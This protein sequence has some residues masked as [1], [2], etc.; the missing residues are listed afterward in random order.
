MHNDSGAG[1]PLTNG[2]QRTPVKHQTT[3]E[4][5]ES[6]GGNQSTTLTVVN[7]ICEVNTDNS[8]NGSD[9]LHSLNNRKNLNVVNGVVKVENFNELSSRR[10]LTGLNGN[11]TF[12]RA[13]P[14][15]AVNSTPEYNESA[16]MSRKDCR[17]LMPI[18]SHQK[19]RTKLIHLVEAGLLEEDAEVIFK[20]CHGT[21]TNQG[22]IIP[23]YL[24]AGEE[25]IDASSIKW[26]S[27]EYDSPSAFA[28][29]VS[30][31]G[32]PDKKVSA[33]GWSSIKILSPTRDSWVPL[34]HYRQMYELK[35]ENGYDPSQEKFYVNDSSIKMSNLS[36]IVSRSGTRKIISHS[37]GFK[38]YRRNPALNTKIYSKSE[39]SRRNLRKLSFDSQMDQKQNTDAIG[40]SE[41]TLKS[42]RYHNQFLK[43]IGRDSFRMGMPLYVKSSTKSGWDIDEG[44]D[45]SRSLLQPIKRS[46]S[47]TLASLENIL[48]LIKKQMLIS[49]ED[50]PVLPFVLHQTIPVILAKESSLLNSDICFACGTIAKSDQMESEKMIYCGQCGEAYHS[51]CVLK[52]ENNG[53][54]PKTSVCT[55]F[56]EC[57]KCTV[58][59]RC[60]KSIAEYSEGSKSLPDQPNTILRCSQCCVTV[61]LVCQ[62]KMDPYVEESM[63]AADGQWVCEKCV[64]CVECDSNPAMHAAKIAAIDKILNVD[65]HYM[66]ECDF[67]ESESKSKLLKG[68]WTHGYRLCSFC[69]NLKE[70]G[71]ICPICRKLYG[72]DDYD[73]PM[74]QCDTCHEWIHQ[75]CDEN[76]TKEMYDAM[77]EDES[78][79][80]YCP[81]CLAEAN[82]QSHIME[83]N[84]FEF[85]IHQDLT[86][87][88]SNILSKAYNTSEQSISDDEMKDAFPNSD[89]AE[90]EA[91][92]AL[93][94]MFQNPCSR[95]AVT[96]KFDDSEIPLIDD[97][98][99]QPSDDDPMMIDSSL[100]VFSNTQES[101]VLNPIK[102]PDI[103]TDSIFDEL[104][105]ERLVL[106][107]SHYH[108]TLKIDS[109]VQSL[110]ESKKIPSQMNC[111]LCHMGDELQQS[112]TPGRLIPFWISKEQKWAHTLCLIFSKGVKLDVTNGG[113][114]G[115][116]EVIKESAAKK[117]AKCKNT[118]ASLKCEASWPGSLKSCV[119]QYWHYP[120]IASSPKSFGYRLETQKLI[121]LC[122][123]HHAKTSQELPQKEISP[124]FNLRRVYVNPEDS[125]DSMKIWSKPTEYSW[126]F[127]EVI[128]YGALIIHCLGEFSEDGDSM[129]DHSVDYPIPI[130]FR[131]DRLYVQSSSGRKFKISCQLIAIDGTF[132]SLQ[133]RKRK[134]NEGL[135]DEN[136]VIIK[137]DCPNS[138]RYGWKV[139]V[140]EEI[141]D[142]SEINRKYELVEY[143]EKSSLQDVIS[144][145]VERFLIREENMGESNAQTKNHF[146]NFRPDTFFGL[147]YPL[148][149]KLIKSLPNYE[150]SFQAMRKLQES[151]ENMK[152]IIESDD[153]TS[154][155][156]EHSSKQTVRQIRRIGSCCHITILEKENADYDVI[157]E[158]Q[159]L[160]SNPHGRCES[161]MND[162]SLIQQ[163]TRMKEKQCVS[164]RPTWGNKETDK[165]ANDYV[166]RSTRRRGSSGV[167]IISD[168]LIAP[169]RAT[170]SK[171]KCPKIPPTDIG[172]FATRAFEKDEMIM[173]YTG[174]V[175]SS[176]VARRLES[177]YARKQSQNRYMMWG[178]INWV[179]DASRVGGCARYIREDRQHANTYA[180]PFTIN[181]KRKIALFALRN[182]KCNEEITFH[183]GI[184]K[185]VSHIYYA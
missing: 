119:T 112:V 38:T 109:V 60:F 134:Y 179:I 130:G 113:L 104:G 101:V 167:L 150:L 94:S 62:D 84:G 158:H 146:Y 128:R 138:I 144:W 97:S 121:L 137:Y 181:S 173:E 70:K 79:T 65:D 117:C 151:R 111:V 129:V 51:F 145:L 64:S 176:A 178:D 71:N 177:K 61:H 47:I 53:I 102:E 67:D 81:V 110:C 85:Q 165:S 42:R 76:M 106:S 140:Q 48:P 171:S 39:I 122:D 88:K 124:N 164:L 52:K 133:T 4:E 73:I 89:S 135:F 75:E 91:A 148:I 185:D 174:V 83:E 136:K 153:Y 33:N 2:R 98:K 157:S 159:E 142:V 131:F 1:R 31:A 105:V 28:A 54:S 34:D 123:A 27:Q 12:A 95:Q 50:F 108:T 96:F 161:I 29:A 26:L 163:Y 126:R 24:L 77:D 155:R 180:K 154:A 40:K 168:N 68:P 82:D 90:R 125:S 44:F 139:A 55:E 46:A 141:R 43:S 14:S 114:T 103:R 32:R 41:M 166:G 184:E 69:S 175:L 20:G 58:C 19:S 6:N 127:S 25:V 87:K 57:P 3:Q 118:G 35:V 80:Y 92:D 143:T 132:I 36:D 93:I 152:E 99:V 172:V 17:K 147:N 120:C 115:V 59:I 169:T 86:F 56:W 149:I 11:A 107:P 78:L 63:E 9:C 15:R 160:L 30:T 183:Y 21:I 49:R 37:H 72:D 18:T 182:I 74:L 116:Q 7:E 13:G 22:T 162:S 10:R 156:T 170:S 8:D 45:F 5:E 100:K 66:S 23:S 16:G